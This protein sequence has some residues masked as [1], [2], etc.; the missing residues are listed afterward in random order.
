MDIDTAD[1]RLLRTT[2][3]DE[4]IDAFGMGVV[5]A[6]DEIAELVFATRHLVD[7]VGE[8]QT[9]GIYKVARPVSSRVE[10]V[11][12]AVTG[13]LLD[14]IRLGAREALPERLVQVR[15]ANAMRLAQA[16]KDAASLA[17]ME[18]EQVGSAEPGA[19][20]TLSLKLQRRIE[21]VVAAWA[22]L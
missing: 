9:L 17:A 1:D 4:A 16:G 20:E 11:L 3:R 5:G 12:H 22:T 15:R 10:Q 7:A 13:D 19:V 2:T 14:A 6:M 8:Y 21:R 18:S